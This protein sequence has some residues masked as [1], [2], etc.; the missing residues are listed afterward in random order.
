MLLGGPQP[1]ELTRGVWAGG[2]DQGNPRGLSS[3]KGNRDLYGTQHFPG[4]VLSSDANQAV[5]SE[6]RELP[7]FIRGSC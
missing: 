5:A 1:P 7:F 3:G 6:C 2:V 4:F